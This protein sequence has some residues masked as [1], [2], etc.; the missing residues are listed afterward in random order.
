M[1]EH[2]DAPTRLL[3]EQVQLTTA[4]TRLVESLSASTAV[5][6][7]A[8]SHDDDKLSPE[9]DHRCPGESDQTVALAS[10]AAALQHVYLGYEID[11]CS[12]QLRRKSLI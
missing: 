7:S 5:A 3:T 8:R 10:T 11:Q 2:I 1:S 4:L 12:G 6:V 9:P